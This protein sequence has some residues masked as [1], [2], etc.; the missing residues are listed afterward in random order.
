M[1]QGGMRL[2]LPLIKTQRDSRSKGGQSQ[3]ESA[4]KAKLP[5]SKVDPRL[6]GK[7]WK[8]YSTLLTTRESAAQPPEIIKP[9]LTKRRRDDEVV[10][11]QGV[12]Q[13]D[14]WR[15]VNNSLQQRRIV[16][17]STKQRRRYL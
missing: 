13:L 12:L 7:F 15:P 1:Q 2:S 17:S 10:D 9:V 16:S 11:R 5:E 14:E 4:F 6:E 8:P 3:K